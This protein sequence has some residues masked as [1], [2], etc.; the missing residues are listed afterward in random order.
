MVGV[1]TFLVTSFGKPFT[2]A[3]FSNWMRDRCDEAGLHDCSAHG[4]RK[5]IATR[6]AEAGMSERQ[7]MAITG[8]TTMK[9]VERY[10][11]AARQKVMA[12]MAMGGLDGDNIAIAQIEDKRGKV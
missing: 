4:L 6:L 9:E 1:R 10:M 12:E 7:I 3:G 11:R 8:H 5:A 2:I